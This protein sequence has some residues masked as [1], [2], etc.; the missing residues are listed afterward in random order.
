MC[1]WVQ[2]RTAL[3]RCVPPKG[4]TVHIAGRNSSHRYTPSLW[5]QRY[6]VQFALFPQVL[7]RLLYCI[8]ACRA[9]HHPNYYSYNGSRTYYGDIP[10]YIEIGEHQYAE[11]QLI[12]LWKAKML[13]AWC[14]F[15]TSVASRPLPVNTFA[16]PRTSAT[17]C[18]QIYNETIG[19]R[20]ELGRVDSWAGSFK[21]KTEH[22]WD[23]FT[24]LS[25]LDWHTTRLQERLVVPNTGT[26]SERFL[27][28]M[29]ARNEHIV[30][31]GQPEWNHACDKCVATSKPGVRMSE[32]PSRRCLSLLLVQSSHINPSQFLFMT[33]S[34]WMGSP[35]AVHA[36]LCTTATRISSA[37]AIDSATPI[38]IYI[39]N[40]QSRDAKMLWPP[41]IG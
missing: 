1:S 20:D 17:N 12:E 11:R 15:P 29:R 16:P 33:R 27:P 19:R 26:Q 37:T 36:V 6:R 21:L 30:Y 22:V 34:L 25:L 40:V 8:S 31:Y 2:P 38:N 9:D 28:A 10:E 3:S 35:L 7:C 24:I 41:P 18:A 13:F 5:K 32:D 14:E 23:A 4:G 39:S